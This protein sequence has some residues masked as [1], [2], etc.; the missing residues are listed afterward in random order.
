VEQKL[1]KFNAKLNTVIEWLIA[2]LLFIAICFILAQV[3]FRYVLHSPLDWTEQT[4]RYLFVW[5]MMM[6]M[7]VMFYR[8]SAMAFDLILNS[9]HGIIRHIL[10]LFIM[11]LVL[12][13]SAYWGYHSMVLALK[14]IGRYSAG[15]EVPLT[16]MY[17]S[18]VI[19]NAIVVL[20]MLE[21][22]IDSFR[23]LAAGKYDTL[24]ESKKQEE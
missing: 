17:L 6:G 12:A 8:K 13:F 19:S 7:P 10:Q 3:L 14:V 2:I 24:A 5:M 18:M 20:V 22:I 15:V 16:F 23:K 21:Q 1:S 9:I 11:L 4:S